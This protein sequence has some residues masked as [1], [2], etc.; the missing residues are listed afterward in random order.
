MTIY[1]KDALS[2]LRSLAD[3]TVDLVIS[4]PP[5]FMGKEYDL[6]YKVEDFVSAHEK[7]L[8]ALTRVV[9]PGGSICW[10]VGSHVR[11]G[12]VVPLDAL[13]YGV[14]AR[15]KEIRLRNRIVWTFGQTIRRGRP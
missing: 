15:S 6:S 12:E 3:G 9:K 13:V 8:C 2:F 7:L 5:Y 10:Q 1:K 14:F 11:N 4:S